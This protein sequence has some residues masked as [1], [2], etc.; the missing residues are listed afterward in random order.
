L[1]LIYVTAPVVIKR[2][3]VLKKKQQVDWWDE[4]SSEEKAEIEDGLAQAAGGEV[5][6][7]EEIMA[8]YQQWRST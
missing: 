1:N 5:K 3:V 4:I 7:H 6:P 2:F 8:K